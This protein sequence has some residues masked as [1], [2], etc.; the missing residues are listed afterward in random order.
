MKLAIVTDAWEPQVNGVVTTL[1]RTRVELERMGHS[2]AVL[3]PCGFR[4]VPCPTYPEIRLA[5]MPRRKLAASLDAFEP[6]AVHVATEGP[7]GI[8]ARRHCAANGLSFTASYHTQFPQYVRKRVPI[9]ESWSYAFLRHHHGHASRTLV[10]TE[11]QR[12]DLLDHGFRNVVIWSRGVDSETFRP[13]GKAH[14]AT[15]RPIWMYAGRVAVEKNLDA[16]LALDLPGTKVVVGDGPDRA[17]LAE[18][19]PDAVFAGYRFGQELARY[20]SAADVFVFPS[21]TDTFGLVMLEAMACGT[22]VAAFPVTGPIDVV[23]SGV[24][25]VLH[26][27]LATA[28]LAAL[29]IDREACRQT[30]LK[31]SWQRASAEFLSHL[32][33]AR[34]G[35]DLLA[36]ESARQ[37]TAT[38]AGAAR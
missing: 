26:E 18:R 38:Y 4:T 28:S 22:P 6:D 33:R 8:A 21:R 17:Q 25:G 14:L 37:T 23:T 16:F 20:L 36:P 30:A 31:R 12:R 19:F 9:P 11:H 27:D 1:S 35:E 10:A 32:V 29:E 2:V 24:D 15:E 13:Y 5:L 7:L 3:A 34:D